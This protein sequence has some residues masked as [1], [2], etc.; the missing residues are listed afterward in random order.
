MVSNAGTVSLA[1]H[2]N[3]DGQVV[4]VSEGRPRLSP[5]LS[6]SGSLKLPLANAVPAGRNFGQQ[7]AP[8]CGVTEVK[9]DQGVKT[10]SGIH[11]PVTETATAYPARIILTERRLLFAGNYYFSKVGS[12]QDIKF[13]YMCVYIYIYMF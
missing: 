11:S 13:I 6:L 9:R 10:W 8:V 12:V 7:V 4:T 3:A 2:G 1:P 5:S